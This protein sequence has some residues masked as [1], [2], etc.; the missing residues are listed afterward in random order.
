MAGTISVVLDGVASDRYRH[1]VVSAVAQK[2]VDR[3]SDALGALGHP[4]RLLLLRYLRRGAR[5]A[6]YLSEVSGLP[7]SLAG[8][9]L[10]VLLEAGFITRNR[11]GNFSCYSANRDQVR[12][13][14]EQVLRLLGATDAMIETSAP[15][16]PC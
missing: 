7:Q 5:S 3:L 14:N 11:Q 13:L 12:A 8:Y 10:A 4:H 15:N 2:E 1:H 16:D 9:H 6:R